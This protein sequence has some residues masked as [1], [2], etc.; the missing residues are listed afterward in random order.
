MIV[1]VHTHI[2]TE[3]FL[4]QDLFSLYID[5][6]FSGIINKSIINKGELP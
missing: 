3:I 6:V 1:D 2:F 4:I 5:K